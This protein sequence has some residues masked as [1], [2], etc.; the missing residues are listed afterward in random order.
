MRQDEFWC[1]DDEKSKPSPV[2]GPIALRRQNEYWNGDEDGYKNHDC[3]A[4]YSD[5]PKPISRETTASPESVAQSSSET[6]LSE[7][8]ASTDD[9]KHDSSSAMQTIKH[10]VADC[11]SLLARLVPAKR[12]KSSSPKEAKKRPRGAEDAKEKEIN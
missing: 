5:T 4:F 6:I 3:A 8:S 7:D 11:F 9:V 12:K 2:H 1:G 10:W